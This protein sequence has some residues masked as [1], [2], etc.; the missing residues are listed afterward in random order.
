MSKF[1]W[2]VIGVIILLAVILRSSLL[3]TMGLILALL[4]AVSHYWA[5][6]CLVGVTYRRRFGA[7][8]LFYGEETDLLIEVTNAKP[9]P[10]AWLRCEDE[11]PA[12]LPLTPGTKVSR[13]VL[14]RR[15]LVNLFSLRWYERITRRYTVQGVRRGAWRYG[16]V[17]LV[18]GDIFGFAVKRQK[19]KL[20]NSLL[21]YPRI[22]PI[23]VLG[24]PAQH[25]FGEFP[26]NRRVLEDPL[27]TMGAREYLPGDNYRHIHWKA[28]ARRRELQTK[29]FEPSSTR[30]LAL[31]L[32][33]NTT[34]HYFEGV[35]PAL[36]EFAITVAASV[37][38]W[39]WE[40]GEAVGL[41]SNGALPAGG[42]VQVQPSSHPDQALRI[43]EALARMLNVSRWPLDRVLE[44][45]SETL[46]Y[47]TTIVAIS[48][49]V[50]NELRR[51][52]VDLRRRHFAV[53]L[54]EVGKV[55]SVEAIPGIRIY[56]V[57]PD[58]Q[59]MTLNGMEPEEDKE[60][61]DGLEALELA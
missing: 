33:I 14:G 48:A 9:L 53:T 11:I 20:E 47:G 50:S 44:F 32:D 2:V 42:R 31:F 36:R 1:W 8:R 40:N 58:Q 28:T 15:L 49:V 37:A 17:Q 18:S 27:R 30:P 39:A 19:L 21:V 46:R 41:Y 35:D 54:I 24:L 52:L 22:L 29:V 5:R 59:Q 57:A 16:P 6:Y 45:E 13:Y 43:L 4:A 23:T 10:L 51:A 34:Q 55:R 7:T 60:A 61:I 12:Q 56:H 3:F 25:P 38:R 26:S